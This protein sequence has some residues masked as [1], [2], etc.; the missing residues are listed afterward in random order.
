L[1]SAPPR[2][3]PVLMGQLI[4]GLKPGASTLELLAG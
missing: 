2:L 1:S 4:A 3:K